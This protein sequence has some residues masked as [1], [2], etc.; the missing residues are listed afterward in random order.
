[1]EEFIEKLIG[2]LEETDFNDI[3][4]VVSEVLKKYGFPKESI[5]QDEIWDAL[6]ELS[7]NKFAIKIV[8][9][10]AE[11]YKDKD[12]SEWMI[13]FKEVFNGFKFKR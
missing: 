10:L 4:M 9:Q 3:Q 7:T 8:N 6:D 13:W 1:M 12:C 11:E 2:R 5:I